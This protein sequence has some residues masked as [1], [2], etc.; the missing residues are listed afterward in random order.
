[1][2]KTKL[3]ELQSWLLTFSADIALDIA[4]SLLIGLGTL[5]ETGDYTIAAVMAL[6]V[7]SARSGMK[8]AGKMLVKAGKDLKSK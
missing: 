4:A 5:A 1:M 6:A 8:L 2:D 3:A 7:A